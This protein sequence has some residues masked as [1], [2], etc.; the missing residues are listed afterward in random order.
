MSINL[1]TTGP[2]PPSPENPGN[3]GWFRRTASAI[4]GVLTWEFIKKAGS[5]LYKNT[6]NLIKVKQGDEKETQ[7]LAKAARDATEALNDGKLSVGQATEFLSIAGMPDETITDVIG[8]TGR[9]HS[10]AVRYGRGE[11]YFYTEKKSPFIPNKVRKERK[12]WKLINKDSEDKDSDNWLDDSDSVASEARARRNPSVDYEGKLD[13]NLEGFE[14]EASSPNR[15]INDPNSRR[16][17]WT[18]GDEIKTWGPQ[19][20][21]RE[22]FSLAEAIK[23]PSKDSAN[24]AKD[25]LNEAREKSSSSSSEYRVMA[26]K[27]N[28]QPPWRDKGRVG[29]FEAPAVQIAGY[30]ILAVFWVWIV[31]R[32]NFKAKMKSFRLT[33]NFGILKSIQNINPRSLPFLSENALKRDDKLYQIILDLNEKKITAAQAVFLIK[34]G[35]HLSPEEIEILVSFDMKNMNLSL[36][37]PDKEED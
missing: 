10:S 20:P 5:R 22:I 28:Y 35:Y 27:S 1:P 31:T 32:D 24:K 23:E 7:Y 29:F 9:R 3:P 34:R 15:E 37:D 4:G 18:P 19:F 14:T 6:A 2:T 25:S 21:I 33:L 17:G 30:V 11:S 26:I 36:S 13:Q 12:G 16:G 8:H